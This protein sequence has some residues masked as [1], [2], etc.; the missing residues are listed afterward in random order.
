MRRAAKVDD[1]QAAI[2]EALRLR[3]HRVQSLAALGAGVPDLLVGLAPR[4]GRAL[5]LLEVKTKRNK[6]GDSHKLTA[7]EA[8][9]HS[10]WRHYPVRTVDDVESAITACEVMLAP[11]REAVDALREEYRALRRD[12]LLREARASV[13]LDGD[14]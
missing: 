12:A 13:A 4:F 6:R 9:W 11:E 7:R 1:N 2:V 3:G 5:V 8:E 14:L 10:E